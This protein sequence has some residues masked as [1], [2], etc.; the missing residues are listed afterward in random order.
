M[1]N[2]KKI[3]IDN[4]AWLDIKDETARSAADAALPKTGGTMT[5]NVSIQ[6]ADTVFGDTFEGN[7]KWGNGIFL[8]DSNNKTVSSIRA[9]FRN[10]G[11]YQMN[12]SSTKGSG[13]EIYLRLGYDAEGNPAVSASNK[14]LW[15]NAFGAA[16]GI[17]PVTQG[18][19]GLA[20]SPSMLV[21]LASNTA[22]DILSSAPRP[23]VTGV[24]PIANGGIG[25]T[26]SG[27]QTRSI[28][29]WRRRRPST[30]GSSWR[31]RRAGR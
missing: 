13:E 7:D 18:G 3:K 31:S 2:V 1:A 30:A 16:N 12:I 21:N 25:G 28:S 10:S 23:G 20:A 26:D 15:R 8:K 6:T 5:G 19:T 14:D 11:A 27:W 17:W 22:A 24:L 29:N 4:G 9:V